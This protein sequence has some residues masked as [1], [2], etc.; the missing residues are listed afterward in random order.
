[1]ISADEGEWAESLVDS[2]STKSRELTVSHLRMQPRALQRR[3]V[4]QWLRA[5]GIADL[6][7]ETIERVRA[8]L[9]PKAAFA[10]TNLP[11]DRH[12]RRRAGKLFVE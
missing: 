1:M 3:T 12:A 8:L 9:E 7:F 11:R 4:H 2:R 5:Q 10:K 6:D